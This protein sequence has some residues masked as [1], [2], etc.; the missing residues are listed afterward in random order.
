MSLVDRRDSLEALVQIRPSPLWVRGGKTV[1]RFS[2]QKPLGALGGF[3][4]VAMIMLGI[5][6][7]L[8]A[9]YS[10]DDQNPRLGRQAPSLTH[11]AG[12]D[13][14]GRDQLSRIIYGARVSAFVGFGAVALAQFIAVTVGTTSAYYGGRFDTL[15]QRFVDVWQSF[16]ALILIISIISIIGPGQIQVIVVLGLLFS[17]RASRIV[18]GAVIAIKNNAYI[19]AARVVGASNLRIITLH[20]L[21]NVVPIILVIATVELGAVILTEASISFLGFGIPPPFP[22][23][24]QMLSQ[25]RSEWIFAPWL[26]VAP[27]LAISLA[28]FGFNM[29]GDALRD[30]LDPRLRGSR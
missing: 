11:L 6:A 18:R 24:G 17:S 29:F 30:A 7:P 16:P 4:V 23:W 26:A 9:P 13:R 12:T 3:I 8:V 5:L 15:L 20:I 10:Y 1:L 28:V 2:R 21:P 22:S 25:S 27:G 14:L 19:E